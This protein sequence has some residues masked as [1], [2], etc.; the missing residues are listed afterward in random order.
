MT[1]RHALPLLA[2]SF[3]FPACRT[4]EDDQIWHGTAFHIPVSLQYP[5]EERLPPGLPDLLAAA[6]QLLSLHRSD[7]VL[8]RLNAEGSLAHPPQALLELLAKCRLL[9]QQSGGVFDPTIQSYWRWLAQR[10]RAGTPPSPTERQNQLRKVDFSRVE[11]SARR[12]RL[13]GTQLTLNALAQGYLTDQV[14]AFLQE[15]HLTRALV[16]MGEYR[17]FG[18]KRYSITIPHPDTRERPLDEVTLAKEALAVSSGSGHRLTATGRDNHL[19]APAEGTSP[20]ARRTIAVFA[21]DALT[22]DAWATIFT[23][24]PNLLDAPPHGLRAHRWEGAPTLEGTVSG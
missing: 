6:D 4:R 21:P 18:K 15:R 14:T 9:H 2:T 10:H 13:H 17:A 12:I 8:S 5:S 24:S 11:F 23:L 20:P 16:N 1:R 19:L 22:A 3:L 7:S